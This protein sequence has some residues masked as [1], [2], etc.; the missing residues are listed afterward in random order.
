MVVASGALALA[1]CSDM[2]SSVEV[3][4]VQFDELAC[5]LCTLDGGVAV[6]SE[7][8]TVPMKQEQLVA[9]VFSEALLG[10]FQVNPG[11]RL[12]IAGATEPVPSDTVPGPAPPGPAHALYAK[13]GGAPFAQ[14]LALFAA[15][16]PMPSDTVPGPGPMGNVRIAD[17]DGI[18]GNEVVVW[19]NSKQLSNIRSVSTSTTHLIVMFTNGKTKVSLPAARVTVVDELEEEEEEVAVDKK[20]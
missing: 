20:R 18:A 15:G 1:A 19:L 10:S 12:Q 17:Y 9:I 7:S 4:S 11:T 2:P 5:R 16:D 8:D 6:Y 14:I 3:P 13:Q